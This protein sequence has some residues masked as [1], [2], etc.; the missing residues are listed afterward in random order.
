MMA[1]V[2]YLIRKKSNERP[3]KSGKE[4]LSSFRVSIVMICN[5]TNSK[6]DSTTPG[7]TNTY[8][9]LQTSEPPKP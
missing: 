2:R 5:C 3:N 1:R 4:S 6:F 9:I 7:V 8:N